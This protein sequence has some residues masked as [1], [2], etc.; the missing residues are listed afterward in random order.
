MSRKISTTKHRCPVCGYTGLEEAAYDEQGCPS[1][2][3]CPCCGT[4]FGYDDHAEAH[5]ELRRKWVEGGMRWWSRTTLPPP[6]W[7]PQKQLAAFA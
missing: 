4:E 7:E 6:E 1:F 5:A 2:D 3:I